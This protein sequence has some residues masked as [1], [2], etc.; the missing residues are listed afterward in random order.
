MSNIFDINTLLK[1][2]TLDGE[3]LAKTYTKETYMNS[4]I[5]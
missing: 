1:E 5:N 4:N 2:N 3:L